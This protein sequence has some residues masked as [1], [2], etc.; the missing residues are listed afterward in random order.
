MDRNTL[1]EQVRQRAFACRVSLYH[2]ATQAGVSG[3]IITRWIKGSNTPS[4]VT[5]DKFERTLDRLE[6]ERCKR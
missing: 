3:T 6:A 4:L 1:M 5:I 2:L